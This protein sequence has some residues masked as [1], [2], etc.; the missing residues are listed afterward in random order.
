MD[1]IG[2]PPCLY[3]GGP[4]I[5]SCCVD[6]QL[7]AARSGKLPLPKGKP[8][9]K[10]DASIPGEWTSASNWMTQ[11]SKQ[12]PLLH[13]GSKYSVVSQCIYSVS[14]T[15]FLL[16]SPPAIFS[17]PIFLYPE[18]MPPTNHLNKNLRLYF[19]IIWSKTFLHNEHL[20]PSPM[21]TIKVPSNQWL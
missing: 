18:N 16:T 21:E 5:P 7:T 10:V 6:Q 9:W 19:Y 14:N 11:S 12:S 4:C 3:Q 2:A 20:P 17:F 13:C 1:A 8:S 15:T